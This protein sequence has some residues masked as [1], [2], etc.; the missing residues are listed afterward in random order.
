MSAFL[1]VLGAGCGDDATG[2]P[3]VAD[4]D[5]RP[6]LVITADAGGLDAS[7]GERGEGDAR[8]S[9]DPA[10]LPS[11]SVMEIRVEGPDDQRV[12]GVL[13][14]TGTEP[15]DLDDRDV[16]T[17]QPLVDTGLQQPGDMVTVVLTQPGTLALREVS[18]PDDLL[19]V[20][21]TAR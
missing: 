10:R 7:V 20:E 12:V 21:V 2:D 13:T 1:L 5:L 18:A 3:G 11:G 8:V 6:R 15:V 9:A 17:P 14:P 4:T 16:T 19:A